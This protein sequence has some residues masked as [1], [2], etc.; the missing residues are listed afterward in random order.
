MRYLEVIELVKTLEKRVE[1]NEKEIKVLK[2]KLISK[3]K[4]EDN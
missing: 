1:K 4:K 2:K 3:L